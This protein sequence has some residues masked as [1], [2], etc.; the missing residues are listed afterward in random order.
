MT[1]KSRLKTYLQEKG[2]LSF[3]TCPEKNSSIFSPR[4]KNTTHRQSN[5]SSYC[6][7]NPCKKQKQKPQKARFKMSYSRRKTR[8]KK[9][10]E[11]YKLYF[12]RSSSSATPWPNHKMYATIKQTQSQKHQPEKY[13][14]NKIKNKN[15]K[16]GSESEKN[17]K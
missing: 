16:D 4:F 12:L 10:V 8:P 9:C 5:N 15:P 17:K 3:F 7:V 2:R 6:S 13:I 14:K 11:S 1:I